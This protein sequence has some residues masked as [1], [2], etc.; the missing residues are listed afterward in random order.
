MDDRGAGHGALLSRLARHQ[1]RGREPR[2]PCGAPALPPAGQRV[3]GDRSKGSPALKHDR[4]IKACSIWRA[5]DV[6]GDVPA[7]LILE[8]AF[9]GTHGFDDFVARTGLARSVVSGRLRKLV[10]EDCLAKRP[11]KEGRGAYYALTKKGR[12]NF[13]NALMMLRWQ[14]RWEAASRDFQVN[15]H[16]MTCDAVIEPVPVCEH[17]GAEIDPRDVDWREGPGLAQ[18]VPHYDRRRFNSVVGARR[19]GGRPLVDAM[20]ELF[21]DRWATLV[22][23]AMFT[24]INRFDDIQRDTSMATNILAGRLERLIRQGIVKTVPYSSH[25]DRVEYR[26]T[27]KGRDLYPVLLTLLQWGDRWFS[28]ERGPPLLL[29]HRS[30]GHDLHMIAACSGCGDQLKPSSTRALIEVSANGDKV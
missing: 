1:K 20:I 22:V 8:Q 2:V 7:L 3:T 29:T 26:L 11:R 6:V 19:P 27:P 14:H 15:L 10:E 4:T 16:H 30:C 5:L 9:L 13:P 25:A 12:D 18:V 23:R 21:G 28:D 17:C 24:R